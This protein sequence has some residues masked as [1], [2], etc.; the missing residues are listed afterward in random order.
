[1]IHEASKVVR[2]QMQWTPR[3]AAS[4]LVTGARQVTRITVST[5]TLRVMFAVTS[6]AVGEMVG[7]V[8]KV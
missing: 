5:C 1:M 3:Y 6:K 8:N 4:R 2:L 7:S